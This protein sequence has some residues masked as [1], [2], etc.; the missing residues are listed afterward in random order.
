M[1]DD[2]SAN[3]RTT[4]S[5]FWTNLWANWLQAQKSKNFQEVQGV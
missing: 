1:N 5:V 3:F 4:N 2:R